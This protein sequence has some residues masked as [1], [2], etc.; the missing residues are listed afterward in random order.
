MGGERKVGVIEGRFFKDGLRILAY[1]LILYGI[2]GLILV[3]L[4][5][6]G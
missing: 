1:I 5:F 6:L 3:R 2:V 4:G